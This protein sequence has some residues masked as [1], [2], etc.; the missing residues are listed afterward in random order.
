[1]EI[2]KHPLCTASLGAPSDMQD[3][4]CASLPVMY[5][6]DEYGTWAQSFWKPT[7]EELATMNAGGGIILH[8][9]AF[10]RQHPVVAMS[11]WPA[12]APDE[13][14]F[15]RTT[16]PSCPMCCA[17]PGEAHQH[18]CPELSLPASMQS[19]HTGLPTPET[20]AATK[21]PAADLARAPL[22]YPAELTTELRAALG[23]M[24]FRT[25]PIAWAYRVAGYNIPNRREEEQA[26]V[27]D[28]AIRTVCTHG[29][30]WADVFAARIRAVQDVAIEKKNA[31]KARGDA[32]AANAE[33]KP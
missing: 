25:G 24:S 6:H 13:P 17:K 5:N 9:R 18:N 15:K 20:E 10:G 16:A 28:Q 19:S 8:V 1:M 2:V 27:L 14:A 11:T 29:E 4:S 21:A 7:A 32:M 30:Q 33:W 23:M 12:L 22:V 31:E 3:G 26:F